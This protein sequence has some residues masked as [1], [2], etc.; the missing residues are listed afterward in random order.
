MSGGM[1]IM[2]PKNLHFVLAW[3][4]TFSMKTLRGGAAETR[5]LMGELW[6]QSS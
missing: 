5:L 2:I 1:S 6:V 4:A 3:T